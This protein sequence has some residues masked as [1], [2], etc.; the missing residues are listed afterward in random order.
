MAYLI[1]LSDAAR[2]PSTW[3]KVS[4]AAPNNG[5]VLTWVAGS[6]R[7]EPTASGA[8]VVMTG[9]VSGNSNANT[10]DKIKN[11]AVLAGVPSDRQMFTYDST[12]VRWEAQWPGITNFSENRTFTILPAGSTPAQINTALTDYD[13][14]YLEYGNYNMGST[15]LTVPIGKKLI[16]LGHWE[17]ANRATLDWSGTPATTV[18]VYMY[19][20]WL[21]NLNI[22]LSGVAHT[23]SIV[24]GDGTD[25]SNELHR[26]VITAQNAYDYPAFFGTANHIEKLYVS[27]LNGIYWAGK[28]SAHAA[29]IEDIYTISAPTY[30]IRLGPV[31]DVIVRNVWING[32]AKTTDY[33]IWCE[34]N[35]NIYRHRIEN[36][37]V[38]NCVNGIYYKQTGI[39]FFYES[40]FTRCVANTCTLGLTLWGFYESSMADCE[41][42]VSST[43]GFY[44]LG[45]QR[46]T[47][48]GC[49]NR[50]GSGGYGFRLNSCSRTELSGCY[51]GNTGGAVLGL[52][53]F[54]L[55]SCTDSTLSS[56]TAEGN[57]GANS[58]GIY[59]TTSD[60]I[61]VTGFVSL[62]NYN[63]I[64]LETTVTA[65]SFTGMSFYS[66]TNI[67]I[68]VANA[69][70]ISMSGV[71]ID[72]T[73]QGLVSYAYYSTFTGFSIR[74]T[75]FAG[76]GN[77][78]SGQYTAYS[79][80]SVFN[81]TGAGGGAVS[82]GGIGTTLSGAVIRNTTG[83]GLLLGNNYIGIS[84]INIQTAG[85]Y[86]I[87][88]SGSFCTATGILVVSSTNAGLYVS[89][90]QCALSG[91]M[92]Y[93][94]SSYG[95]Y[96]TGQLNSLAAFYVQGCTN[97][98][99]Y[100]AAPANNVGPGFSYLNTGGATDGVYV[101]GGSNIIT[102]ITSYGNGRNG[103]TVPAGTRAVSFVNCVAISNSGAGFN[104]GAAAGGSC[105]AKSC[106]R[107]NNALG[108]T[109][110]GGWNTTDYDT[111]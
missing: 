16:G 106:G 104:V 42:N 35:A 96:I 37:Y 61:V 12:G 102:G 11:V 79:N 65:S 92:I 62:S 34:E 71:S 26:V 1:G 43:T 76:Y 63:G 75:Q 41:A 93:A 101:A 98:G 4:D 20:G 90:N 83:I 29:V 6:S 69:T 78:L 49:I 44:I 55:T 97:F 64:Y 30:G 100:V 95:I 25:I 21:E 51:C 27:N 80:F 15:Q 109:W 8:V 72:A 50:A 7:W 5:D 32:S 57:T 67:A 105:A 81:H 85:S 23:G 66:T 24:V 82:M 9:D 87:Q 107:L 10:V 18:H 46:L 86:G 17:T 54:L 94:C 77:I 33:G 2:K 13:V 40:K 56:C 48:T 38:F 60:R 89:G 3:G 28:S 74:W 53:A 88:M 110:G 14:V 39:N 58:S 22:Y 108:D 59:I 45:A 84:N 52:G 36:V 47:I 91:V 70:Y 99:L 19:S 111:F 103:F 73:S 31:S 68:Y